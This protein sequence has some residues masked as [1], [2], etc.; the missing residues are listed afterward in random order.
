MRVVLYVCAAVNIIIFTAI[1][2]MSARVRPGK[3]HRHGQRN[4]AAAVAV[5]AVAAAQHI[6]C[7]YY[8]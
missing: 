6:E 7:N 2:R 4:A 5:D 3:L 1:A 8:V